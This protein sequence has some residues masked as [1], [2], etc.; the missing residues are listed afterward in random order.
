M[1]NPTTIKNGL[2]KV[3]GWRQ[4]AENPIDETL[5]ESTS[6][7][8]YQD[9]HPLVTLDNVRAI[10]P[11]FAGDPDPVQAFSEWLK[12]KTDASILKAVRAIWDAKMGDKTARH[13]LEAKT[14]FNGAGNIGDLV[15]L[16]ENLVG[17]ELATVAVEGVAINIDRV[18]LQFVG[19]EPLTL[20]LMHSS[21]FEP[22]EIKT[23]TRSK[24]TGGVEWFDLGWALPY[25]SEKTDAGGRWFIVYDQSELLT[26]RAINKNK[27]W[28]AAPCTACDASERQAFSV[29]SKYLT[30]HPFKV[31][32]DEAVEL[33]DV[34]RNLYTYKNNY[35]LNFQITI[36][37][38][39]SGILTQQKNAFQNVIGLQ[40]A[41]DML[42][43]FAYNP[44]FK[45]GRAQLNFSRQE[46]LYEI[47]G[48]SQGHKK[49]GLKFEIDKAVKAVSLDVSTTSRVC[50]PCKKSGV[51][52][53]S[54]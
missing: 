46:L 29:W 28:N 5:T 9:A 44:Q 48:D 8:F 39:V 40:V 14:L 33:W 25:V 11:T 15:P 7:Q 49:S 19:D 13:I 26:T 1:Y 12:Q 27:D 54:I 32:A 38:D 18:G 6:G 24:I 3:W 4:D 50:F 42:R 51:K 23:F 31:P 43:E 37:C 2:S 21:Q 20:Y 53:K 10:A 22:I 35:G 30:V 34:S 36:A 45:V 17:F 16:G 52:Y 41:A 47:D